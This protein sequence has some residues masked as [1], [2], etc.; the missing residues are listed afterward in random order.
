L[1]LVA[2]VRWATGLG[3][4]MLAA[5]ES[6]TVPERDRTEVYDFRLPIDQDSLV[7]RWRNAFRIR[8]FINNDSSPALL[9]T[10]RDAFRHGS[11]AWEDAVLFTDFRFA[12]VSTPE[13]ADVILTWSGSSLPVETAQ[14]PPGGG[15]A[16]TTFCVTPQRD[17]LVPFPL[18]AGTMI[19]AVRFLVT[20]SP[21]VGADAARVRSLIT[22]ELGHVLG[23]AQHSPNQDDLMFSNPLVRAEPNTR[24][25]ATIQ[26][27]YQTR[28]DIT[29]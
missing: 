15:V 17:R 19:S 22:H 10:L 20:I 4:L 13:Q 2:K 5:C 21:T 9:A 7:M 11:I 26:L 23:I 25:R 8:V 12:Q 16:F 14:C 1:A 24:D 27:L 28:P 3:L 18:R 6:A 29:P